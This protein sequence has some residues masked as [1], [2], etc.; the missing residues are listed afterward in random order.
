MQTSMP[1]ISFT[2]SLGAQGAT[3]NATFTSGNSTAFAQMLTGKTGGFLQAED[4]NAMFENITGNAENLVNSLTFSEEEEVFMAELVPFLFKQPT[5]ETQIPVQTDKA[6]AAVG[7]IEV[8]TVANPTM[9]AQDENA[10]LLQN[11]LNSQAQTSEN[12]ILSETLVT[13][14]TIE[15]DGEIIL[16]TAT[17]INPTFSTEVVAPKGEVM[18]T[19]YVAEIKDVIAEKVLL[20]KE[21]FEIQLQPENL[22]KLTIKAAVESGKTIV[23][24]VCSDLDTLQTLTRNSGDLATILENRS[25][26]ET[27]V[28]VETPPKDFMQ[29]ERESE[30]Q[31]SRQQQENQ[32]NETDF[33]MSNDFLQQLRLGLSQT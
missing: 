9:Q 1:Q 26:S 18:S 23:T 25:G 20:G 12:G 21:S 6:N 2:S 24:I 29:Q 8:F 16:P 28:I 19:E 32:K 31:G 13:E 3:G 10:S 27:Q 14:K 30:S 5:L 4:I 7:E 17:Q 15:T 22:G 11:S 33:A